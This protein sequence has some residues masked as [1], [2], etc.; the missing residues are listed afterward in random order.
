[1]NDGGPAFPESSHNQQGRYETFQKGMTLRDWFA[2]QAINGMMLHV[3]D[4]K[5]T[6]NDREM[7][8]IVSKACY[9]LADAMLKTREA[10][11]E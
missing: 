10:S 5:A 1:M 6:I 11:S 2:G 4:L 8:K 7:D 3:L 9:E